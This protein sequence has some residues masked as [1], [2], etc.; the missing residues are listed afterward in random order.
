MFDKNGYVVGI[1]TATLHQINTLR[2]TGALPQNVN[3]A[4]KSDYIMP[5]INLNVD[6]KPIIGTNVESM[7]LNKLVKEV[8]K[9]VV[10][11]IVK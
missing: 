4:V 9:S 8:E 10:L 7:P 3:Y 2:A 11:V 6:E 5:L 1:I